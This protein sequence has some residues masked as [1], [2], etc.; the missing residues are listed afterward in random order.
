MHKKIIK[1][2]FELSIFL[3][4]NPKYVIKKYKTKNVEDHNKFFL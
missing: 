2:T 4:C 1:L 3:F